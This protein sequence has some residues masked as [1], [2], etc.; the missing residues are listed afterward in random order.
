MSLMYIV[1]N[2]FSNR[3]CR[4]QTAMFWLDALLIPGSI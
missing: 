1:D 3:I 4:M 2:S